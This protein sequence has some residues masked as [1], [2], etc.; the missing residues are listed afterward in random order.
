MLISFR[1]STLFFYNQ[2]E[3]PCYSYF[4]EY[5]GYFLGENWCKEI[6]KHCSRFQA[7][8]QGSYSAL[9]P[10]KTNISESP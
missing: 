8:L 5:V 3:L 4:A 7:Y 9:L 2:R 6:H 10:R 1:H